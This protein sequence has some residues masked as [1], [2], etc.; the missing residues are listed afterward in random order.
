MI[1]H[2][3]YTM[4]HITAGQGDMILW[5]TMMSYTLYVPFVNRPFESKSH[6]GTIAAT[7][8]V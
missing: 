3:L 5:A 1:S 4:L 2:T 8:P 6:L 7:Y